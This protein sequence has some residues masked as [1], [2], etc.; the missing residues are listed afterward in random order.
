[1]TSYRIC[2]SLSDLRHL[3]W[4]PP[5][6]PC[7]CKWQN[8]ILFYDWVIVQYFM[9]DTQHIFFIPSS[10]DEVLVC[11]HTVEIVKNVAMNTE[12]HVSFWIG[13]FFFFL[14]YWVLY[15]CKRGD[16]EPEMKG[17][18]QGHSASPWSWWFLNLGHQVSKLMFCV[19]VSRGHNK[20]PP[21][22]SG[23][24]Q[25]RLISYFCCIS[26]GDPQ[27]LHLSQSLCSS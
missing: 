8:F 13:V 14:I 24:K 20:Q 27:S 5:V 3:A 19:S 23:W 16:R 6:R 15:F 26:N 7:C 17:L 12:V 21:S 10:I 18:A 2:L 1:M 11:F 9:A 25:Q 4:C 22:F